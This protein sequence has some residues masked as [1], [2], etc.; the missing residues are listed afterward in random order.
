MLRLLLVG[1]KTEI[2]LKRLLRKKQTLFTASDVRKANGL[3]KEKEIDAIL[4]NSSG[5]KTNILN[6][7]R[8][9]KDT[10]KTIPIILVVSDS[11]LEQIIPFMEE[12]GSDFVQIPVNADILSLK[13]KSSIR[14]KEKTRLL[15]QAKYERE[16]ACKLSEA[17]T[18]FIA[19]VSHEF[20]TPLASMMGYA[21]TMDMMEDNGRT[22]KNMR[23]IFTNNIIT[24]GTHL[25]S[26]INDLLDIVKIESGEFD[27]NFE[28]VSLSQILCS[29]EANLLGNAS[30]KD[31]DIK[32]NIP[33]NIPLIKADPKRLLQVLINLIGN[34]IKFTASGF[35]EIFCSVGKS[36]VTISVKDSGCGIAQESLNDVFRRFKQFDKNNSGVGS[37]LG[38][39]IAKRL[40]ELMGG[41]IVLQSRINEGTTASFTLQLWNKPYE[42]RWNLR[43]GA[44]PFK[45]KARPTAVEA[46]TLS[47][48]S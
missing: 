34:A 27:I 31:V 20:R 25:N 48:V 16:K 40:V 38:L 18:D 22:T 37:G 14:R 43:K 44:T 17:K 19:S 39:D 3:I 42:Q 45:Q 6:L 30:N 2:E 1:E 35:V 8:L 9:I 21:Q 41:E 13:I 46:V 4:L 7:H 47:K 29:A 12:G 10:S 32:I 15:Q 33:K 26:L 24:A 36:M 23:K 28:A 5:G 11:S